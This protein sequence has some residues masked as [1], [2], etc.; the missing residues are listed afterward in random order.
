ML[1][2]AIHKGE[3]DCDSSSGISS[4]EIIRKISDC[5]QEIIRLKSI[6]KVKSDSLH[7]TANI[8][9]ANQGFSYEDLEKIFSDSKYHQT[10]F[11]KIPFMIWAKDL[12]GVFLS[13]NQSFSNSFGKTPEE[14]IG[15]NDFDF[16]PAV[17][18]E[19]YRADDLLVVN[20]G[21]QGTF[22]ELIPFTDGFRWH[23][24][25]KIPISGK[26][27]NVIGTAGLARDISKRKNYELAIKESEAKFRELA[28]STSDSF[29]IR[30]GDKIL[31]ANPAFE[32][33][34]GIAREDL[35]KNPD[36][37]L[38][39]IHP[40]D[41]TRIEKIMR[42]GK[43]K[44]DYTFNEQYRIMLP[45]DSVNWIWHRS[46][47]VWNEKGE[48]YRIVS[49]SSN[50]TG[51]KVLE[52]KVQKFQSQQQAILDNIPHLAWIKDM[53][54]KYLMVNEAFCRFFS[55]KVEEII[56]KTDFDLCP[57]Q[58]AEDYVRKDKE[59]C[60]ERKALRFL[61]IEEN[62]FGKRYSETHKTPVIN[63]SG[64]V[65]GIAGISRD[66]T[67]QKIAEQAL[68]KSEEKFK[69]LIT[70]LPEMVFET[71]SS[72][73]ITF[74]NFRTYERFG[75][76]Q[77]DFDK[78]I[79]IYDLVSSAD[80]VRVQSA[81]LN[82]QQGAEL[83]A[84]EYLLVT[85]SGFEFPALVYTNNM[86]NNGK[87]SGLRGVMVDITN[88]KQ[89]EEKEKVYQEKLRFLSNTALDFLSLMQNE[90]IYTYAGLKLKEF[91]QEGYVLVSSFNE[92]EQTIEVVYFSGSKE[93]KDQLERETGIAIDTCKLKI[94]P[95]AVDALIQNSEQLLD[96]TDGVHELSF[97][98]IPR[99]LC[100][101]AERILQTRKI[102]G[103]SL[104]RGGKLYGS[105]EILTSQED[106]D[107]KPLIETFIYQASIALHR[108]QLEQELIGAK[109]KA[110]ESDKLKTAFLA[111]MSHEIRT[112]M[113]G[114]IGI[115]QLLSRQALP[116]KERNEYLAM[117]NANGNILMNLV[118]DII[119][120]SK[121]ESNQVDVYETVFSLNKLF[122]ELHCFML[123]EKM[124]KKKNAVELVMSLEKSDSDSFIKA[125]RQ[126]LH[127][128]LSNLIGNAIKF[129]L[130]G[131][132]EFGYLINSQQQ[133]EFFIKDTGIGVPDDKIDLIFNRFTQADQSLTR[134]FGGSGLGLAI[135]KGFVEIMNGRIWVEQ[136]SSGGSCFRFQIPYKPDI[137]EVKP[138]IKPRLNPD[139]YNWEKHTILIV[140]DNYMSFRLLQAQLKKSMVNILHADNG[141]KSIDMVG[142]H[143]EIDLVLMDIQLPLMN[144]Y[145]ATREI[146]L[147]RPDLPVIAQTANALDDDRLKCLNSGCSDYITKPIVFESFLRLINDYIR[148]KN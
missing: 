57:P 120:I 24:T 146:K 47:P 97:K 124:T 56:G 111:N 13:A 133:V 25:L 59:V 6:L 63:E 85:K 22:E 84:A 46:Y 52:D 32:Q 29:V 33:I 72:G 110:E 134:P 112:P 145:E 43:R 26:D 50:I 31:Y 36:V 130:A 104:L 102:Y 80:F 14:V 75:Y 87:W 51:I 92:A 101:A 121:I 148:D 78:G 8:S 48:V 11:N 94:P 38:E 69:D 70:L 45:D 9:D 83:K 53:D 17:F 82:T 99:P 67:D 10:F 91:I 132:V 54:G 123:G 40:E 100:R 35:Y 77:D 81:I 55:W 5:E 116:E 135:S 41:K 106:L 139:D 96:F 143:P 90:N 105:I 44:S 125:D 126:K 64:E 113:N 61:E 79:S 2:K 28:E 4:E 129:T 89:S 136:V 20:T 15:R 39:W 119:D 58:L 127:Q 18:A 118:N 3:A 23:E 74:A 73:K 115:S 71:N 37:Y 128:V 122:N 30:S 93:I 7:L 138:E 141:Q 21:S 76:T 86:Y 114:I 19:K 108:R 131:V 103:L 27:G 42:S 12:N 98:S 117:I 147:I 95:E 1:D 140:E 34:Y 49:V 109:I 16:F 65:I 137:P 62:R 60:V 88:R 66:I 68:L 142:A 144:G 107:D